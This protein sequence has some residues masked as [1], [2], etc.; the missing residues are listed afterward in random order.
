MRV[1]LAPVDADV[2]AL[3]LD[4]VHEV[5][6]LPAVTALPMAPPAVLGLI[7]LRGEV[8][9][10]LDGAALLGRGG[11]AGTFGCV[12]T[13]DGG[14]AVITTTEAPGMGELGAAVPGEPDRPGTW[15]LCDGRLV[16]LVEPAQRVGAALAGPS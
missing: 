8:L 3:R 14:R 13:V 5:L 10:V 1:L 9:A 12:V 2:L 4:D 11:A 7:T 15:H 6:P 16:L